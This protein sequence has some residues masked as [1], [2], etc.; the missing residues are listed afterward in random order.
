MIESPHDD[1][2]LRKVNIMLATVEYNGNYILHRA[3]FNVLKLK[4][5]R[6]LIV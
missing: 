5:T 6:N 1:L 3:R 2:C 4:A